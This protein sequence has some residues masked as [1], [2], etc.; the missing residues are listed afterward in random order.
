RL[1]LQIDHAVLERKTQLQHVRMSFD[2]NLVF[3]GPVIDREA[4]RARACGD[5]DAELPCEGERL[6]ET[7]LS[8]QIAKAFAEKNPRRPRAESICSHFL[9]SRTAHIYAEA[10]GYYGFMF[11][12]FKELVFRADGEI[13]EAVHGLAM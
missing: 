3:A 1:R 6:Q 9:A 10:E 7:Q 13:V 4:A 12:V 8:R 11:V 2:L 5:R